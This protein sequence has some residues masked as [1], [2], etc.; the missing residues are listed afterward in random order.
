MRI[1]QVVTRLGLGGA[2]RVAETLAGRLVERGHD[3]TLV[4]VAGTRDESIAQRMRTDLAARGVGV[5]DEVASS[6]NAKVAVVA[7]S[8]RLRRTAARFRPDVVH[9][10]TEI[11]EFAWS[12]ARLTSRRTRSIPVVRTVHNTV[13]WGGW[14]R[15]GRIAERQLAGAG[16]AAVS[17]SAGDA[18]IE[19]R[20]RSGLEPADPVVIYNGVEPSGLPDGPGAPGNPPRL[21][22][23]GRFEPQKGIDVLLGSLATLTGDDPPASFAIHG[24]GSLEPLVAAAA[25]ERPDRIVAGPPDANL[26]AHIDRF[27]AVLMPSRFEGL[28]LLALEALWTG[29]PLLATAAPGLDEVFPAAYPDRCPPGDPVAFGAL[30]RDFLRDP[31]TWRGHALDARSDARDRFSMETMV[32]AYERLYTIAA[33]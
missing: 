29:I 12:L 4:T 14:G 10:H 20:Q 21:L 6:P 28:P 9:L 2:E 32:E 5:V 26:R 18:F 23:A 31:A 8:R 11:P 16:V 22:F 33:G 3:V 19:W 17:R 24:A 7:A 30:I 1:L 25:A 15:I 13:L 27:D